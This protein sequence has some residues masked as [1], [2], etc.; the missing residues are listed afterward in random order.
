MKHGFNRYQGFGLRQE[1]FHRFLTHGEDWNVT[2]PLGNRQVEG[3]TRWL[4][5]AGL[6]DKSGPTHLGKVM[7]LRGK[8]DSSIFWLTIWA[9]LSFRSPVVQWY[10]YCVPCGAYQKKELVNMLSLYRDVLVPNRTDLNA[11]NAL[12]ETLHRSPLGEKWGLGAIFRE[13]N[14]ARIVKTAPPEK[15]PLHALIV[16][17]ALICRETGKT[18]LNPFE[19]QNDHQFSPCRLFQMTDNQLTKACVQASRLNP[20]FIRIL[21]E[22]GSDL[23]EL[24][25]PATPENILNDYYNKIKI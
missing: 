25:P 22:K 10:A 5:D 24:L 15:I 13:S 12:L 23:I 18:R 14:K 20:E 8:S 19:L 17:L 21:K 16:D 3:F 9:N 2:S 11:I 4:I 1:W 7:I 6:W